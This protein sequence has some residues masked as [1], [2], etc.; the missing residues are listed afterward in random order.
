MKYYQTSESL[1]KKIFIHAKKKGIEHFIIGLLWFIFWMLIYTISVFIQPELIFIPMVFNL[2]LAC[3][4]L[5]GIIL[6]TLVIYYSNIDSYYDI[7][8]K[9]FVLFFTYG[10]N[11]YYREFIDQEIK[12]LTRRLKSR[13]KEFFIWLFPWLILVSILSQ[14]SYILA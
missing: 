10:L 13:I 8:G 1:I 7:I 12:P 11:Y 9:I 5:A 3:F 6:E 4:F 14:L 2:P